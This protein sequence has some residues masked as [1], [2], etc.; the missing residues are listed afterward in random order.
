MGNGFCVRQRLQISMVRVV[1][2]TR[3][4]KRRR[5][6]SQWDFELSFRTLRLCYRTDCRRHQ[7]TFSKKNF[8]DLFDFFLSSRCS[9][10]TMPLVSVE[11]S[12]SSSWGTVIL[13]GERKRGCLELSEDRNEWNVT[14][15]F[16]GKFLR[17]KVWVCFKQVL[18]HWFIARRDDPSLAEEEDWKPANSSENYD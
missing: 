9:F 11:R 17:L 13:R 10:T 1:E 2:L 15:T 4:A 6:N 16:L 18:S 14:E 12:T 3:P 5:K 7:L 8:R